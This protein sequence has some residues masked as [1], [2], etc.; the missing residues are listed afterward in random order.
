MLD[1]FDK[2]LFQQI[3]AGLVILVISFLLGTKSTYQSNDCKSWKILVIIAW[4]MILGG[5][6]LFI[7]HFS[8][9]G[10]NDFYTGM[11]LSIGILGLL[12]KYFGKFFIWWNR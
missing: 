6:Y 7:S 4:L 2:N 10:F 3:V 9:G 8:N 11:G 5:F 12:L 1:F